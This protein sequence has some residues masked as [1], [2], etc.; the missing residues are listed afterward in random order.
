MVHIKEKLCFVFCVLLMIR[1]LT[2][3]NGELKEKM[4]RGHLLG[5]SCAS[6]RQMGIRTKFFLQ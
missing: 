4:K 3:L 2:I 1:E 5:K 6:L